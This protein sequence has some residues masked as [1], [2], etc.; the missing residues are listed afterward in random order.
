MTKLAKKGL[1]PSAIGVILRDQHGI[2]Q[3]CV[4]CAICCLYSDCRQ[5]S[6][7]WRAWPR[8]MHCAATRQRIIV[9][10]QDMS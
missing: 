1:T 4:C 3:V 7:A 6:A 8:G 5:A 10:V 9:L 2:S